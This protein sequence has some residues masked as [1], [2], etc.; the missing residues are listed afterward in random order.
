MIMYYYRLPGMS[1]VFL[2]CGGGRRE[3][4]RE[5]GWRMEEGKT[6]ETRGKTLSWVL[7]GIKCL[8]FAFTLLCL[9]LGPLGTSLGGAATTYYSTPRTRRDDGKANETNDNNDLG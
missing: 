3:G 4:G 8:G 9:I 7:D 2:G 6:W 1:G 5:G